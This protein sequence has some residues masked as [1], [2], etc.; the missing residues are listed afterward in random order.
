MGIKPIKRVNVG[1]QVL[2][3]LKKMLIDGEWAPGSK[4]P[5]ENELAE[6]FE[7]SRITVRQALQ[8][9]NAL[10]LIE[11]RLGDGSYVRNLDIGDSMNALIPF[12]YLGYQS[13]S[14]VF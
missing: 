9:L 8:K 6:L 1:E 13:D 7:V 5:S 10:G 4:I 11:T 12:I 3:Q 2:L 14:H